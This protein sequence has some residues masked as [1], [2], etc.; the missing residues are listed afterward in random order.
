LVSIGKIVKSSVSFGI[1]QTLIDE[2]RKIAALFLNYYCQ[3]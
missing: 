2:K 1:H 3:K